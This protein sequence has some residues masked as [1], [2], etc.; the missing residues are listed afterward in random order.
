MHRNEIFVVVIAIYGNLCQ[1]LII[2]ENLNYHKYAFKFQVEIVT[3]SRTK[4][5]YKK[6]GE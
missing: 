4:A 6:Y 5:I 1:S 2:F 3:N